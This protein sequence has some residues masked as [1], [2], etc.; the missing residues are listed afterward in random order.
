MSGVL[1]RR[2]RLRGLGEVDLERVAE[3]NKEITFF[4]E[5]VD[6]ALHFDLEPFDPFFRIALFQDVDLRLFRFTDVFLFDLLDDIYKVFMDPGEQ[7]I[8]VDGLRGP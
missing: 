5:A 7:T 3:G 8:L 6:A 2:E 1:L 4:G